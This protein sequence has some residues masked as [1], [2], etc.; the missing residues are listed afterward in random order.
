MKRTVTFLVY[1]VILLVASVTMAANT[2]SVTP[3]AALN[4]TNFGLNVNLDGTNTVA[5]VSSD[6]PN[7]EKVYRARFWIDQRNLQIPLG[8]AANNHLRFFIG[9]DQDGPGQHIIGFL[10]KS[11]DDGGYHFIVW[12]E[13]DTP[14]DFKLGGNIFLG[15]AL[16]RQV[17]VEWAAATAPGANDG[18]I[19]ISRVDNPAQTSG[20]SD[21]D[22]DTVDVDRFRIG[23]FNNPV[24]LSTFYYMDEFESFRTLAP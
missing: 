13:A 15:N 11:A 21:I 5:Y 2:V 9:V 18:F 17:E 16:P 19:Q 10:T 14:N 20:R 4:G 6:H 22:N 23:V 1:A 7:N 8:D 12:V 24:P 3:G